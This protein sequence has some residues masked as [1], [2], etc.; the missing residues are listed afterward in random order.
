M[1]PGV[2]PAT[3]TI[4]FGRPMMYFSSN[5]KTLVYIKN[6]VDALGLEPRTR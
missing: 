5:Y 4:L 2:R 3:S 1:L 6:L